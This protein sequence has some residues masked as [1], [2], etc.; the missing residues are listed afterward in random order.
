MVA[1]SSA[2]G[3]LSSFASTHAADLLG[4]VGGIGSFSGNQI[5]SSIAS[6][7]AWKYA[8]KQN[9]L[10]YLTDKRQK[11]EYYEIMRN[12]LAR[13]G[14]NPLL[15]LGSSVSG[16]SSGGSFPLSDSDQGDQAI[17]S[18]LASIQQRNE[19][20]I[21]KS[22]IKLNESQED[23]NT[24][25][26]Y[27]ALADEIYSRSNSA[28]AQATRDKILNDIRWDNEKNAELVKQIRAETKFTN[29]RA[30]GFSA[31]S[32]KSHHYGSNEST[33][34]KLFGGYSEGNTQSYSHS[35]SRTW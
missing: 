14:Y 34:V 12:S 9:T 5:G 11:S 24:Q 31:T 21:T 17:Q 30:R 19:N 16:N 7:R 3:A 6:Q 33:D 35:D 10:Q 26:T 29:E 32:S 15:A 1:I 13:G 23:L 22:Q 4:A 8:V 28:V 27:K 20:K 2:L 25:L 18:A